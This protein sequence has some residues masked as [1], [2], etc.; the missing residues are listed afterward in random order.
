MSSGRLF[1]ACELEAIVELKDQLHDCVVS[2][3]RVRGTT[4]RLVIHTND[5]EANFRGLPGYRGKRS[6]EITLTDARK[7][8]SFL[9]EGM[10]N[11]YEATVEGDGARGRL[12]LRFWP[13]GLL[14]AAFAGATLIE[15]DR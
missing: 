15:N 6:G 11:I 9:E 13:H 12:A 1:S 4:D 10:L 14:V 8:E 5:I 2:L 3:T 7:I